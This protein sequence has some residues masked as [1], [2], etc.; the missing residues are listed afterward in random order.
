MFVFTPSPTE[1]VFYTSILYLSENISLEQ[2]RISFV[3]AGRVSGNFCRQIFNAGCKIQKIVSRT[4]KSSRTLALLYNAVWSPDPDFADTSDI[5]I[6]AVPDDSLKEVLSR[7]RCSDDTLVAHTAG[8]LG[9]EV[10]TAN[11]KHKG[12]FY[13]L[14]TF[15]NDRKIEFTGLPFLLEASDSFTSGTLKRLGELMGGKVYFVDAERRRMLH[16]A[17]VFVCNFTNYMLTAGDQV[18]KKAGFPFEVLYPLINETILKAIEIGPVKSQTGPAL[19]IDKG[20]IEKHIDLLS[21]SP[22][23]Q[24]LYKEVTKS[25]IRFYKTSIN[26]EF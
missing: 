4:E 21:F 19:R 16:V 10:F 11:I 23:L 20:T 25:I 2:L 18:I 6:T 13:P 12:V 24:R 14:Q 22:E 5:I 15:S 26:D 7:I 8:S 17:A 9:L 1:G 3:G